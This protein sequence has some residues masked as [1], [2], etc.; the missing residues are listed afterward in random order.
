MAVGDHSGVSVGV[1]AGL[2]LACVAC[3]CI[4]VGVLLRLVY[5]KCNLKK[6]IDQSGLGLGLGLGLGFGLGLELELGISGSSPAVAV[7][8]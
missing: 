3:V 4:D 5:P 7:A 6:Y 1:Y 2:S 8:G